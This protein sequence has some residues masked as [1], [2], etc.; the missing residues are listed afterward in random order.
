MVFVYFA[1]RPRLPLSISQLPALGN[2]L[3][4]SAAEHMLYAFVPKLRRT[5]GSRLGECGL[6]RP[7]DVPAMV[8]WADCP[9]RCRK[10]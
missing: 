6:L 3:L 2:R 1:W 8:P 4:H 7:L 9:S 5:A 10:S